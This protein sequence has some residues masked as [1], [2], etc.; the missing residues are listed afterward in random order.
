MK[1]LHLMDFYN[2]LIIKQD[3]FECHEI[4]EE[5][6]KSKPMFTKKDAEVFLILLAT[7]EYHY[8][9]GNIPGAVKS[10][11]RALLL[12]HE[13]EYDLGAL[14]MTVDLIDM[15]HERLSRMPHDAFTP[16]QFP[17][18]DHIWQALHREHAGGMTYEAFRKDSE[19]RFVSDAAVVCKHRLRDRSDVIRERE[20]AIKKRKHHR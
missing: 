9:R 5:A 20:A 7:G 4:M 19:D 8:R 18:T 2:E 12:Y 13:N 11:E 1:L 15:M 3:Y 16:M 14:G 17:L 10:Y 6:W